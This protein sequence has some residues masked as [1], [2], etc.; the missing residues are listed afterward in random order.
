MDFF[1]ASV[2]D[3]L[4]PYVSKSEASISEMVFVRRL[5]SSSMRSV[6]HSDSKDALIL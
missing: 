3:V 1:E 5:V 2:C 4:L 6:R